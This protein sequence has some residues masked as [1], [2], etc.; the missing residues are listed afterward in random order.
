M[1]L[2]DDPTLHDVL[3]ELRIPV[4]D[5]HIVMRNG[6]VLGTV[7]ERVPETRIEDGDVIALSGP[8]PFSRGYGAPV[9]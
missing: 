5:T 1:R 8:V 2:R 4:H 6:R 3:R 9:V 7:M